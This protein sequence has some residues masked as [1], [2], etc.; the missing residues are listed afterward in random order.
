MSLLSKDNAP[1]EVLCF[2]HIMLLSQQLRYLLD[3]RLANDG[4]TA[5]QAMLLN[6]VEH[7]EVPPS[8]S[9][10]AADM[11]VSYQNIKQLVVVLERKG[12]LKIVDDPK[13]ARVRRLKATARSRR[14]WQNR[15]DSDFA[16]I[17]ALFS[18]LSGKERGTLLTLLTKLT[19]GVDP[20]YRA[21]R[22]SGST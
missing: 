12:F 7:H 11:A 21:S 22:E 3:R 15:N 16:E 2:R 20:T 9:E 6:V 4:L 13:D 14:Y 1:Q 17:I 5:Q 10:V 19:R 8:L 18:G